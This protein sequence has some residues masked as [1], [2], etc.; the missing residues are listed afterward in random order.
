MI[1][2]YFLYG[3]EIFSVRLHN[4]YVWGVVGATVD[5]FVSRFGTFTVGNGTVSVTINIVVNNTFNG[6]IA[7]VIGSV[8]VPPV[9]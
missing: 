6:V 7:S 2:L 4:G 3:I 1:F 5:G 8:V 9:N